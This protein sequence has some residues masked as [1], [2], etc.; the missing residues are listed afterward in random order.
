MSFRAIAVGVPLVA[1][2]VAD[3]SVGLAAALVYALAY[4]L[5]LA[6]GLI[7]YFGSEAKA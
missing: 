6:V 3:A 5:E 1:V 2:T 7:V 4:S